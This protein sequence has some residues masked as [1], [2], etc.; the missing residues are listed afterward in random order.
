MVEIPQLDTNY[1]LDRNE[2]ESSRLTGQYELFKAASGRE[3]AVPSDINLQNATRILDIAAGNLVWTLDVAAHADIKSRLSPDN[4]SRV[5]LYACD[6]SSKQF[7]PQSVLDSLGVKTFEHDVTVPFPSE[8]NDFF[9]LIHMSM[10]VAA[11]SETGWQKA[12]ENV[13]RILSL[14]HYCT[15][16]FS[17]LS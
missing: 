11:L 13:R 4:A 15:K 8:Y 9:D 5:E 10:L 1:I 2:K 12:L 3:A 17:E 6:V 14:S 16:S 7:P